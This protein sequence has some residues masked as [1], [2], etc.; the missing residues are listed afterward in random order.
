MPGKVM[1]DRHI[2]ETS[3]LHQGNHAF[4]LPRSQFDAQPAAGHEQGARLARDAPVEGEAI[5]PSIEREGR[6]EIPNRRFET[7]EIGAGDVGWVG[8]DGVERPGEPREQITVMESHPASHAQGFRI[9]PPPP[10][11]LRARDPPPR[12]SPRGFRPAM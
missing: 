2:L 7:R 12:R 3:R 5:R 1:P 6:I 9:P 10:Q 8:E 11:A 4:G